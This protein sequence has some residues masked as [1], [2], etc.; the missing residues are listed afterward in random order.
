MELN[1]EIRKKAGGVTANE[2]AKGKAIQQA[3]PAKETFKEKQNR[4]KFVKTNVNELKEIHKTQQQHLERVGEILPGELERLEERESLQWFFKDDI[5]RYVNYTSD[6]RSKDLYNILKEIYYINFNEYKFTDNYILEHISEL[7]VD[8]EKIKAFKIIYEKNKEYYESLRDA[9]KSIYKYIFDLYPVLELKLQ[10]VCKEKGIDLQ[11]KKSIP[12]VHKT[13]KEKGQLDRNVSTALHRLKARDKD[14]E[15][16]LEERKQY[17]LEKWDNLNEIEIDGK[18]TGVQGHIMKY[19]GDAQSAD[20][21]MLYGLREKVEQTPLSD[22]PNF[23]DILRSLYMELRHACALRVHWDVDGKILDD[24]SKEDEA[25]GVHKKAVE[26]CA[27]AG[28]NIKMLNRYIRRIY[29]AFNELVKMY[30]ETNLVDDL[31]LSNDLYNILEDM[32]KYDQYLE[33]K[34]KYLKERENRIEEK[35][36]EMEQME[37][38]KKILGS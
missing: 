36:K 32:G 9:D 19:R 25:F 5:K 20:E 38:I 11:Q 4:K 28:E 33:F 21:I 34:E 23:A 29:N 35:I 24:M 22:D 16:E 18:I 10:T 6:N 3:V 15:V 27:E 7:Y 31:V 30:D 13:A 1:K 8:M 37:K 26:K 17:W 12:M 14:F 2:M